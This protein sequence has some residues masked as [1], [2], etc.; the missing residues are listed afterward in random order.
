M[1]RGLGAGLVSALIA[2]IAFLLVGVFLPISAMMLVYGRQ[3][4]QDA[5]GH[6]GMILLL[7]LSIARVSALGGSFSLRQPCTADFLSVAGTDVA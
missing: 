6:G 2:L 7:T 1:V 5:P 4:V 3:N